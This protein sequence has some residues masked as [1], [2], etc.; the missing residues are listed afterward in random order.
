M[1]K[2]MG[3]KSMSKYNFQQIVSNNYFTSIE[4]GD[5]DCDEDENDDG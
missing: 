3:T 1:V 4:G 5:M 2:K